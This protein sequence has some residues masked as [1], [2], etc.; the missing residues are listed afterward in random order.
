MSTLCMTLG[1]FYANV[2]TEF[3]SLNIESIHGRNTLSV[4]GIQRLK[5]LSQKD[6]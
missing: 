6:L 1:I 5:V 2:K 3:L 4:D